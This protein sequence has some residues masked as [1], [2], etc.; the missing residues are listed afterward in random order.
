MLYFHNCT[1]ATSIVCT[2][3]KLA[4]LAFF[5]LMQLALQRTIEEF[6][7][8]QSKLFVGKPRERPVQKFSVMYTIRGFCRHKVS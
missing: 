6:E 4:L 5:Y 1:T 7:L 3:T 2:V 8:F